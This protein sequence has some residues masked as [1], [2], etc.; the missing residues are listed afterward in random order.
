MLQQGNIC[1]Q[2]S[3]RRLWP[4]HLSGPV[5]PPRFPGE[6][7]RGHISIRDFAVAQQW[8]DFP[9]QIILLTQDFVFSLCGAAGILPF[10][11]NLFALQDE[12]AAWR[13]PAALLC[14]LEVGGVGSLGNYHLDSNLFR[15]SHKGVEGSHLLLPWGFLGEDVL[16]FL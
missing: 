10:F 2:T 16:L 9:L 12:F 14:Y 15:W 5:V 8:Q 1:S 3:R 7:E 13:L 11:L 6:A 4:R